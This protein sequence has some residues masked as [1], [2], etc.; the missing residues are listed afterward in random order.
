[1]NNGDQGVYVKS[2]SVIRLVA[3]T[4][5]VMP[6]IGTFSAGGGGPSGPVI[7]DRG[8]VSFSATLASGGTVLLVATLSP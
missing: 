1:L 3:K 2:G 5:T 6:G 8:Q 7:N 4:G